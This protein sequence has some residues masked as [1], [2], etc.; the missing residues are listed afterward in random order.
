MINFIKIEEALKL[1]LPIIDVRSP[2]E[3]EKGH[4]PKAKN[5]ALFSNDERAHVGTV[6]KQQSKKKAIELGYSYVEPKLDQFILEANKVAPNNSV[7]IHCWRGGMRSQS[8][9]E[10]LT[11]NGFENVRVIEGGYKSYRNYVL[12]YFET[13][14]HLKILGGY[15]GSGKTEI[16]HE[17][18]KQGEQVVDLE[19]LAHHK[20]S[21]FGGIGQGEQ[22]TVEQFQNDLFSQFS[23]LDL[24]KTIW[25][26]D[27]SNN[28]GKIVLPTSLYAQMK[29]A[30]LLFLETPKAERAKHLVS[31]YADYED[32]FLAD[33]VKRISKRLGGLRTQQALAHLAN[34]NY[35]DVALMTLDYYDKYYSRSLQKKS[36]SKIKTL[37][38]ASTNH[39]QNAKKITSLYEK[40]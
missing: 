13:P 23:Q 18:Q 8:F 34:K 2:L 31:G 14:F 35:Y 38:L 32:R 9:A 26:E 37:K 29:T 33:G 40:S 25:L 10:H 6:Y 4:I 28:I 11:A 15:T 20:G 36:P 1:Q 3:Y 19:G 5:I 27:E 7:I 30:D 39:K 21:A 22:P 24:K 17:L 16:L 12:K